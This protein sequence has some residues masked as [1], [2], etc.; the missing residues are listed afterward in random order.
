M[1]EQKSEGSHLLHNEEH[2]DETAEERGLR[3]ISAERA[4]GNS[5]T[6]KGERIGTPHKQLVHFITPRNWSCT[7]RCSRVQYNIDVVKGAPKLQVRHAVS[8]TLLL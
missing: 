3:G 6:P 5:V 2:L 8:C 4:R 7:T 1:N